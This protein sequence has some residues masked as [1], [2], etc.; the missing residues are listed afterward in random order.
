MRIRVLEKDG[1]FEVWI[2]GIKS[3]L[4][5]PCSYEDACDFAKILQE[6]YNGDFA[7]MSN[8]SG[9]G[10][11]ALTAKTTSKKKGNK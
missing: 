1:K 5:W 11:A 8:S 10:V 6:K 4:E 3:D 2:N 9:S 7:A